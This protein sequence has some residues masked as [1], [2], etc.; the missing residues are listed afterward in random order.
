M[1]AEEGSLRAN[2]LT[3]PRRFRHSI[4]LPL[5]QPAGQQCDVWM[6]LGR[7]VASVWWHWAPPLAF[8]VNEHESKG[9]LICSWLTT[10]FSTGWLW[11]FNPPPSPQYAA[12]LK[13]TLLQQ[14]PSFWPILAH[15]SNSELCLCPPSQPSCD[16]QAT[17]AGVWTGLLSQF[18]AKNVTYIHM[19]TL[20]S[21]Y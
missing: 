5:G 3:F 9:S 2:S 12:N 11:L 4:P 6:S 15:Q 18:R 20:R 21:I 16:L 17:A 8:P 14:L 19:L 10:S 13:P 7:P 1:S